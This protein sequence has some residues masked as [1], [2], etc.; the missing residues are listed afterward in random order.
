[1]LSSEHPNAVRIRDVYTKW[2]AGT[3]SPMLQ[4]LSE[5]VIYHLPGTHLGGGVVRGVD[6]LMRRAREH[7]VVFDEAPRNDVLSV[8]ADDVFAVT[9]ERLRAKRL[10]QTLDQTI[11][12]VWRIANGRAVEL[13]SHF[14]DQAAYDAFCA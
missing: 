8:A 1:M 9:L 10:G 6:D 7:R 5:D 3:A 14:E 11:C 2:F 4:F 12:G 13:W